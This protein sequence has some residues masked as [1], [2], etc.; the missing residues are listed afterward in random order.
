M[1]RELI[2]FLSA[3]AAPYLGRWISRRALR[4][5]QVPLH[6]RLA[7]SLLALSASL[8]IALAWQITQPM[9]GSPW[10][11]S[12]FV[13]IVALGAAWT[14][15]ALL[16]GRTSG[17]DTGRMVRQDRVALDPPDVAEQGEEPE[18]AADD[19]LP[20]EATALLQQMS[21]LDTVSIDEVMTPR[22]EIISVDAAHTVADALSAM[23]EGDVTRVLVIE[24][25]LDRV[26]GVAHAKD[27][28]P[29]FASG[30]GARIVRGSV[31]RS[32]RLPRHLP[33][34]RLIEEFRKNRVTVGIVSDLRG[35]TL[36]V[37]TL[38]D[39]LRHLSGAVRE[40]GVS[41]GAESPD[42]VTAGSI[43]SIGEAE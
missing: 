1:N 24:G 7:L 36:G 41:A 34:S 12:V 31:R 26:L 25:S 9:R 19:P 22:G 10:N 37:V 32:I 6:G 21:K 35:H 27:L 30:E 8:W 43:G 13:T 3:L 38:G 15:V 33:A 39:V 28:A 4:G 16:L 5:R 29:L 18:F 42:A 11:A 2:L 23:R 14:E 40:A 20:P 17:R